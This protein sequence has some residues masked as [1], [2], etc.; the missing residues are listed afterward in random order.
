MPTI[1]VKKKEA[2]PATALESSTQTTT[3][4]PIEEKPLTEPELLERRKNLVKSMGWEKTDGGKAVVK[5]KEEA[6]TTTAAPETVTTTTAAPQPAGKTERKPRSRR[7]AVESTLTKVATESAERAAEAAP[8]VETDQE[9][10]PEDQQDFKVF[11]ILEQMEPGQKGIAEKFRSFA[12]ARYAYEAEWTK[13]NPGIEFDPD[14][15]EHEEFYSKNQPQ[16]D[17]AKLDEAR[18][19]MKFQERYQRTIKPQLDEI[20]IKEAWKK[21]MPV[22]SER[23][24]GHVAR[25]VNQFDET[26]GAMIH[27]DGKPNI[28]EEGIAKIAETDPLAKELLDGAASQFLEPMILELEKTTIPELQYALEG[29]NPVQKMI[30]ENLAQAEREFLEMP[31]TERVDPSGRQFATHEQLARKKEKI[32]KSSATKEE[33]QK[34]L[35]EI[36]DGFW[37]INVDQLE[38]LITDKVAR[39]TRKA[40]DKIR[41]LTGASPAAKGPAPT[42]APVV[43]PTTPAPPR[44]VA[45]SI[46]TSSDLITT[47]ARGTPG[48]ENFAEIAAKLAFPRA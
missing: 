36:A 16:V 18:D 9:L 39:E 37:A 3:P 24:D 10:T 1:S 47:G 27:Q 40:Y 45:P 13:N 44:T 11:Q 34:Q 17:E 23:V 6:A 21:A 12:K 35:Q 20:K 26:L 48:Q 30:L 32:L 4:A 7:E 28:T 25:L 5:E 43:Q 29:R 42:R 22:I 8:V 19:E 14:S 41:K 38:D 46:A 33:K 31:E 2:A 15:A